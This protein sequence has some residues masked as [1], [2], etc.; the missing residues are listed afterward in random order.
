MRAEKHALRREML[1]LRAAES[2][3]LRRQQSGMIAS[4][5]FS[6]PQYQTAGTVFCYCS[7][8]EE[9]A[10]DEILAHILSSGKT[11]CVPRCEHPGCMTA[12]QIDTTDQL[13]SGRFGIR[14]PADTRPIILPSAIDLCIVPCLCADME[15]FR[16]GYGGGYYD[17]FLCQTDC[18]TIALCADARFLQHPFEHDPTDIPCDCILT[19]RQVHT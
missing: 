2:S 3:A 18:Y 4:A 1:A 10:T 5:L 6:L 13:T 12:R 9:I 7:T 15:R 17:R 11:L 16:I 8:S 19:E 14:E